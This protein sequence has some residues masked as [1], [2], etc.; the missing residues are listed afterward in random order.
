LGILEKG[1][2][3]MVELFEAEIRLIINP[4]VRKLVW[5]C[6][7]NAPTYFWDVPSSNTGKYHPKDEFIKG[8][9]VLHTKRAVNVA[10]HLCECLSIRN[11][12]RDCV[13]AATIMHDLCKNGYLNNAG[14]TVDGHGYLWTE[15]ARSIY[16]KNEIS[17]KASFITI[18]RLILMHMGKYDLPYVSDW[19]DEL[20]TCVQLADYISSR[21]DIIVDVS[22]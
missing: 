17:E 3:L 12:D 2:V 6:L 15:L 22:K 18:S 14:H 4:E 21:E 19:S 5:R 9:L 16:T 10:N 1:Y 7:E 8:G 13:L 20:A 11:I